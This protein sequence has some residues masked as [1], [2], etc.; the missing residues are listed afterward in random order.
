MSRL[1]SGYVERS[2][3]IRQERSTAAAADKQQHST[4]DAAAAASAAA[5]RSVPAADMP[6]G[7]YAAARPADNADDDSIHSHLSTKP[8]EGL[9]PQQQQQARQLDRVERGRLIERLYADLNAID[10]AHKGS[11]NGCKHWSGISGSCHK[12]SR[13][14][15][16]ASRI[17]GP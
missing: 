4:L 3:S 10:E 15:L 1:G 13:C 14:R 17:P 11:S 12:G 16:A 7:S 2:A 6:V 8:D 9:Q 5:A